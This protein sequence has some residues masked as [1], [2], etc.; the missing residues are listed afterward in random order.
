MKIG[1]FGGTFNPIHNGHLNLI[2]SFDTAIGL[3]KILC[4]PTNIPPHKSE[5]N[6]ISGKDRLNMLTI[7]TAENKK[8]SPCDVE[9]KTSGKSY[10][11]N[12]LIMLRKIY[13]QDDFYLLMGSDMFLSFDK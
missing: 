2:N 3:D 8:I 7:A 12:T 11:Y 5:D 4:I 6:I 10:T 1:I 9:L 13:F